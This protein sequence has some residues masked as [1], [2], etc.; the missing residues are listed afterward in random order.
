MICELKTLLPASPNNNFR[1]RLVEH[2]ESS[3]TDFNFRL[4]ANELLI[5]YGTYL[6]VNDLIDDPPEE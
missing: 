3:D 6:G 2:H 1:E 4:K 5:F